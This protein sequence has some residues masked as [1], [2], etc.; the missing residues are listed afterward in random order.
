[1]GDE[2]IPYALGHTC[3]PNGVGD[4]QFVCPTFGIKPGFVP[5]MFRNILRFQ[6][7]CGV[8]IQGEVKET[9]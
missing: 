4:Y 8:C 2:V 3:Q 6:C 5:F 9:C 7:A 1:M